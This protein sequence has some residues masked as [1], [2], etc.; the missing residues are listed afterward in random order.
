[1]TTPLSK[2]HFVPNPLLAKELERATFLQDD[3][4]RIAENIAQKAKDTA[5][6][7]SGD[8][9]DGIEADSG[10]DSRG[11]LAR[12][13]AND[14]KSALIEFGTSDTPPFRVLTR[15][16]ESLGYRVSGGGK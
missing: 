16:A 8:Y 2:G 5:P 12:V 11:V 13:N 3:L 14:W 9:R 6:E 15:A 7:D 4:A 10:F 1:M